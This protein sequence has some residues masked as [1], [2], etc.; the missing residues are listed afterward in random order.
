MKS[1]VACL[2]NEGKPVVKR[3]I[4]REGDTTSHGGRVLEG[5]DKSTIDGRAIAGVGHKVLCPLCKGVFAISDDLLGRRFP[6]R[7]HGRDTAVDG[8]RATCGA[9]LIASQSRMTIED[10]GEV[11]L[12]RRDGIGTGSADVQSFG[13]APTL[14]VECLRAATESGATTVMRG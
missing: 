3:A 4:I 10:S 12:S 1:F 9:V 13:P 8:M 2:M 5:N 6:H 11:D 14:C 7:M